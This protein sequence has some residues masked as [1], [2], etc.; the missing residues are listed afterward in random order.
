MTQELHSISSANSQAIQE[1]LGDEEHIRELSD[2]FKALCDPTRLRII[3]ALKE[4]EL[5]VHDL[6]LLTETSESNASHQLRVLRNMK[7]VK[8]TRRG[9]QVFYSI[10][11]EHISHFLED[12]QQHLGEQNG[13]E[14][15]SE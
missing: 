12:I 2:L 9:K 8:Y 15:R 4:E 10:D 13:E 7:L 5:C 14:D 11:D 6:A 3:L 1:S